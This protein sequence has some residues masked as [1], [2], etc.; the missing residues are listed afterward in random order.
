DADPT[1]A[2]TDGHGDGAGVRLAGLVLV[3]DHDDVGVGQVFGVLVA[4]L[5]RAAWG[6][7]CDDSGGLEGVHVLFAL[8][9]P[10]RL[11]V[12]DCGEHLGEP[13]EDAAGVAELP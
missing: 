4:P 5:A 8:G 1:A 13:V 6:A 7:G 10:Q 9:N 12:V 2:L 11:P 3:G